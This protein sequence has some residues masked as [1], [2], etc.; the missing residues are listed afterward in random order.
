MNDLAQVGFGLY[1]TV[2]AALV[3]LAA[4]LVVHQRRLRAR[5]D[6]LL[7]EKDVV[8]G[9]VH[10]V[11][12]VFSGTAEA[13]LPE[14]LKRVLFYA[15]RT[16]KAGAGALYLVDPDNEHLRLQASSGVFPPL[17]GGVGEDFARAPSK[18]RYM[19]ERLRQTPIP[20]GEG[21]VG[22]VAATGMAALIRDADLDARVPRFDDEHLHVRSL[23]AVPMRFR[24]DVM[25]VLV[26]I[27]RVDDL[28][29]IPNDI[30][31]LQALADQASVSVYYAQVSNALAEKKRM[32]YDLGM[33]HRIQTS[34]LPKDIPVLPGVQIAAFSVPAQQIGGD[35]YDFVRIDEDHLGIVIADVSGKG[36][37]GALVMSMCR[38]VLRTKAP[39][40]FSPA[41]VLKAMNA[42]LTPDLS[43]D[44]YVT[45]LYMVLNL[46]TREL[47][48]ARAGHLAP[49]IVR[50]HGEQ[51]V[52]IESEGMAVGIQAGASFDDLLEEKT[53]ALR[54]GDVLMGF[55]DG[56]TEAMDRN[57]NEWGLLSLCTTVQLAAQEGCGAETVASQV[58]Q[59]L[60]QF[61]GEVP[62][63]DDMTLVALKID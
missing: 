51:T 50:R 52:R 45:V 59:K 23:L 20:V 32:D 9:F 57:E 62:Q 22:E 15:L 33:A 63:Y 44:M 13:D 61:V 5:L 17:Y 27:N 37:A 55:T 10:D 1:L 8:V 11:G 25:G 26:V 16:C 28:P 43:E 19:E 47:R 46:S 7:Q 53:F 36:V 31:L 24:N 49:V 54:P 41:G 2:E 60:M 6:T 29:F 18:L 38:T 35:Y 21:I 42:V 30:N 48:V 58:R 3:A 14:L 4:G 12:E 34:L 56:V 40:E 39:G